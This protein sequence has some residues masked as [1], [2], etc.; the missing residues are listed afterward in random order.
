M[1]S[2]VRATATTCFPRPRPGVNETLTVKRRVPLAA[3]CTIPGRSKS[4]ILAPSYSNTPGMASGVSKG[5][6][7]PAYC[8]R[9]ELV[10]ANRRLG[11]RGFG[12][13]GRLADRRES[14]Q[15][16]ASICKVSISKLLSNYSGVHTSTLHHVETFALGRLLLWLQELR[17]IL[18]H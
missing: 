11:L 1:R 18:C 13:Q 15:A 10:G 17:A 4:W 8:Q 7:R 2:A 12:Q 14:D 16:H 9:C 3:S 5:K 6:G